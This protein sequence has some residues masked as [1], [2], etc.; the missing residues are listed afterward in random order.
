MVFTRAMTQGHQV[1]D[2]I[3]LAILEAAAS[4][5]G[6]RGESASMTEVAEAAG[7]SRATLYRYFASREDLLRALSAAAIEDARLRLVAADLESV[8]VPEAVARLARAMVGSA[9]NS[10][11]ILAEPQY[12]DK[13]EA[14]L[15]IGVPIRALLQRGMDDGTLRNDLPLELL[16]RL[17]GGLLAGAV[18]SMSQ[19]NHDMGVEGVSAAVTGVFLRGAGRDP[20]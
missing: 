14:E 2:H 12:I 5:I 15:K 4:V 7:I 20:E 19:Q 18:H 6:D 9:V 17:W 13:D 8:P 3:T 1:R 10:S 16:S 11:V